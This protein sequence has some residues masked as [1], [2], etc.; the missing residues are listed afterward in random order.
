MTQDG[1]MG[2]RQTG[3]WSFG[4]GENNRDDL[5]P[6]INSNTIINK[7]SVNT[8]ELP[9]ASFNG[10]ISALFLSTS[11]SDYYAPTLQLGVRRAY[12]ATICRSC[13]SLK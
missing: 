3:M 5:M 2:Y 9:F 12:L 1:P 10:K 8:N 11:P 6:Y 7:S 13:L 4:A